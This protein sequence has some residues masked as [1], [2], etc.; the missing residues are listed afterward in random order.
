MLRMLGSKPQLPWC[1]FGDFNELLE[2][3]DKRGGPPRAHHLMQNFREVLDHCGFVDLDFLGPEFT[4][5][6][7]CG[8]ELI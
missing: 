6:G 2:V 5:H 4:W 7:R 3:H 8:G 1:R